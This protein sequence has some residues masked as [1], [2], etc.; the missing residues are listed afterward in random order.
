MT[1]ARW[2]NALWIERNPE[3][4]APNV[5]YNK[6]WGTSDEDSVDGKMVDKKDENGVSPLADSGL[7]MTGAMAV[8]NIGSFQSWHRPV[9]SHNVGDDFFLYDTHDIDNNHPKPNRAHYYLDSKENL[10]DNPGEWFY[11]KDTH[12]LKFMPPSGSC[13][14]ANSD[15]IRGR[16]IDRAMEISDI[17]GLNVS[18]L[19]FFA[20]NLRAATESSHQDDVNN[21]FLDSLNFMYPVSSHRM[22]QDDSLPKT[23]DVKAK[24]GGP[25]SVT[26]CVF[27]GGEGTALLHSGKGVKIH[28]NLF[29]WNDWS[30]VMDGGGAGTI[31]TDGSHDEEF[32]GNT[33]WYNGASAGYRPGNAATATDNLFA[34]Q[35]DGSIMNDG[36]EVQFMV[37][38]F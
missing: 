24:N 30:G 17:D 1:N 28:N 22:L 34:G 35:R 23:T 9:T 31:W 11:N 3:T 15:A 21:L 37:N 2:P 25:V 29:Q 14:D 36:A 7:D 33:V 10:L 6:Y 32:I 4:G 27:Y 8:L 16:V 20:S 38:K 18:N 5:F 12:V 19:D 26:N 13:P